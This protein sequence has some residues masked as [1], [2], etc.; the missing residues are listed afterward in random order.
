VVIKR[1]I[2]KDKTYV[3]VVLIFMGRVILL[4]V[5]PPDAGHCNIKFEHKFS[6]IRL[7]MFIAKK[8]AFLIKTKIGFPSYLCYNWITFIF[9]CWNASYLKKILEGSL[10]VSVR[11]FGMYSTHS[12]WVT[13]CA[14]KNIFM[15]NYAFRIS[16]I[17][18]SQN[19]YT[20]SLS[21][22]PY[23]ATDFKNIFLLP[24]FYQWNL[25]IVT[26]LVTYKIST[27]VVLL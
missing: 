17:F 25:Q 7:H 13:L 14:C 18:P 9:V 2:K 21:T 23:S 5:P 11:S 1:R 20:F 12:V 6:S 24:A 19:I 4:P 27:L 10:I 15:C 22:T 8:Y 26:F 3:I 16:T